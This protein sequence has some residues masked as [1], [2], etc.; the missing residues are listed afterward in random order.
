[1]RALQ[2]TAQTTTLAH[3]ISYVEAQFTISCARSM[4]HSF[5][6]KAWSAARRGLCTRYDVIHGGKK[7]FFE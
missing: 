7:I 2:L 1:M 3:L 6:R 5:A 4:P